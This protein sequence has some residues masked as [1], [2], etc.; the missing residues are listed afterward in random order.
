MSDAAKSWGGKRKGAGRKS[1]DDEPRQT[2][3]A[4]LPKNLVKTLDGVAKQDELPRSR[5]IEKALNA[6]LIERKPTNG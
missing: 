3:S 1:D 2:V 6:W 4:S 5:L